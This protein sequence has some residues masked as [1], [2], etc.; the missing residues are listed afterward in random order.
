VLEQKEA[1][2]GQGLM[3]SDHTYVVPGA[4][5]EPA[6]MPGPPAGSLRKWVFYICVALRMLWSY[7]LPLC[8]AWRRRRAVAMPGPAA[9]SLQVHLAAAGSR[10]HHLFPLSKLAVLHVSKW[11]L[12][13]SLIS[14]P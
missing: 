14:P 12:W 13:R 4:A 2:A 9:G 10:H 1:A 5:G 7:V 3:G 11:Q 6:A 8:G